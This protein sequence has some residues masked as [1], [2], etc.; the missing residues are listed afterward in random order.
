MT[1]GERAFW[2]RRG[3]GSRDRSDQTGIGDIWPCG[4]C[5]CSGSPRWNDHAEV[6]FRIVDSL[7]GQHL[8]NLSGEKM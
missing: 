2:T 6:F 3:I 7:L 4:C 8:T 1:G 5:R